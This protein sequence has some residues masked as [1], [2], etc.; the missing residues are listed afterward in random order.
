M[1][2]KRQH[3]VERGQR[4]FIDPSGSKGSQ[5]R[6]VVLIEA[7]W[8]SSGY[9]PE[10]VLRRD[11]PRV[12]NA[13]TPMYLDH[14]TPREEAERPERSVLDKVGKLVEDATMHPGG[15]LKSVAEIY[16]HWV[17][18]IDSIAED[19]GLS[20]RAWGPTEFGERDGRQGQIVES[21]IDRESVDYVTQAGAGGRVGQ[22]IES[23]RGEN[24]QELQEARRL[25]EETYGD[26]LI[27]PE[28]GPV[29]NELLVEA[30]RVADLDCWGEDYP[31]LQEAERE[32]DLFLERDVSTAERISLAKK[33]QAIP[34]K[35]DEGNITG[36]RFPMANCED[37]KAAAM[38]VG[39]T[40]QA[41]IK[42]FIKRVASKLSCPVPFKESGSGRQNE[43]VDV[44]EKESLA[45]LARQFREFKESTEKEKQ[46]MAT[47]LQE[48]EARA[49]RAE[50]AVRLREA[51]RIVSAE[52]NKIEGLPTTAKTRIIE[53]ALRGGDVPVMSD[54]RLDSSLLEE[55][56]RAA[57]REEQEY[58]TNLIGG[59]G[60][61]LLES[62]GGNE[63]PAPGTVRGLSESGSGWLGGGNSNG[64]GKSEDEA[65]EGAFQRLGLSESAS[66]VAAEGR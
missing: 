18:V 32:Y 60:A 64:G 34:I 20:I 55:R 8:G 46:E 24:R 54:G 39:R 27:I 2:H 65:L 13:G 9:Y 63:N 28:E 25:L 43:E 42:G 26:K 33:G 10:D 19:V 61:S 44:A 41:D 52:V 35:D 29:G 5:R 38:S 49:Q 48:S 59:D 36:G 14:P 4:A 17:P 50:E 57:V 21:I 12:F 51:G 22:L 23:A 6:E 16:P 7:G 66:K 3:L 1:G 37:V 53:S 45:E 40:E 62:G 15:Q 30:F 11:G 58:L 56:A 47:K 31:L